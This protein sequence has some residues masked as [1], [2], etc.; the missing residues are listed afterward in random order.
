M[1]TNT[2]VEDTDEPVA[3]ILP[4]ENSALT[5]SELFDRS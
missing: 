4:G 2:G 1:V 5:F 3:D